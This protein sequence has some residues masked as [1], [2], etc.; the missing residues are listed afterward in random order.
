VLGRLPVDDRIA[1]SLRFIE[2]LELTEVARACGVSLNTIKRRLDRAE[3][4]FVALAAR[5]PSLREWLDQG[6]R[7]R[8]S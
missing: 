8:S 7:W 3:R 5:E 6:A 1:F 2:G 4:R